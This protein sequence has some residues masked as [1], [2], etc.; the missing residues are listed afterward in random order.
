MELDFP[1][2]R[3]G[4]IERA[5]PI[6]MAKIAIID[7]SADALEL[8]EYI[9]RGHHEFATFAEP[10]AFLKAF[11]TGIFDLILLDLVMPG[12]DG[13]QVFDRIRELDPDVPVVAITARAHPHEREQALR[14]GFCDYFV[15]PIMEI[16]KFREA[17]YSHI[18]KCA[19]PPYTDTKIH[20][21][22]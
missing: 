9:L 1:N 15:K 22:R 19:N 6:C 20:V 10:D 2:F 3:A 21:D 18:G 7:D 17:V 4:G 13:F 14:Q 12:T 5:F 16:E 8:F 11:H